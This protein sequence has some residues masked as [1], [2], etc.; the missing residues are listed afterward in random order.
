MCVCVCVC[1]CVCA[2]VCGCM[3]VCV[4]VARVV[5]G[6]TLKG[7]GVGVVFHCLTLWRYSGID[8]L[9]EGYLNPLEY[10]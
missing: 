6:G 8:V 7:V 10:Y 1:V 4:C 2:C 9:P 3:C 5:V